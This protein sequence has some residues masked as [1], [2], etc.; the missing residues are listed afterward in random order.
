[1]YTLEVNKNNL[2]LLAHELFPKTI[3]E[4]IPKNSFDFEWI[5]TSAID[6]GMP[7]IREDD[8]QKHCDSIEAVFKKFN[9]TLINGSTAPKID[10][11]YD[12]ENHKYTIKAIIAGY[13]KDEVDVTIEG[14]Y[15]IFEHQ[16]AK[17]LQEK[18]GCCETIFK[19][20]SEA[21]FKRYVKI[22]DN[23]DLAQITNAYADGIMTI[24]IPVKESAKPKKLQF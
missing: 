2:S 11:T 23:A 5:T 9:K 24:T 13:S 4:Y 15:I 14:G 10:I 22:P 21:S 17:S 3:H 8:W 7:I 18:E 12:K 1:M 19:E 20:I 6:Y 16:K